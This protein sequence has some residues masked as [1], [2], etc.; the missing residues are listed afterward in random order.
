MDL[1]SNNTYVFLGDQED[2]RVLGKRLPNDLGVILDELEPFRADILGVAVESTF[3][4]YWLVDGLIDHCYPVQLVNPSAIKQYEG[5]KFSDDRYD[6]RWLAHLM[7]LGLL[8]NGYVYPKADRPIR[9]LLRKRCAL[10]KQ[11]TSNLLSVQNI[12]ARNTGRMVSGNKLKTLD[13]ETVRDWLDHNELVLA[14]EVCQAVIETLDEQILRLEKVVLDR[15]KVKP[16]FRVLKTIPG[17]GEILSL[18][19]MLEVGDIRRFPTDRDFVSYCRCARSE[20]QSNH[21]KKGQGN[22]KNGN[23]YLSWAFSEAAHFAR[24]FQPQ[25]RRFYDRKLAKV[26]PIVASRAL[27]AKIARASYFMMRDQVPYNPALL[28]R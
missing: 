22:R 15:V 2:R 24:R 12:I 3:N 7:R 9:D 11:R 20:R 10:I 17:V 16:E 18:T 21:K 26:K 4:W 19:I 6:A 13:P 14:V 25:A 5:K 1:H 28:F 23:P 8:P 27:A